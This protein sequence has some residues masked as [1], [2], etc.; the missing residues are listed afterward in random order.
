MSTV[1]ANTALMTS[2]AQL[3]VH[4]PPVIYLLP[5]IPP[6][7][8]TPLEFSRSQVQFP[9]SCAAGLLQ[10]GGSS[11]LWQG[12][13]KRGCSGPAELA[14]PLSCSGVGAAGQLMCIAKGCC[15]ERSRA[16]RS[17]LCSAMS[18]MLMT[19][20]FVMWC[21]PKVCAFIHFSFLR[22]A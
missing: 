7:I 4:I 19:A 1:H 13:S 11:W 20:M 3:A 15:E 21:V 18:A 5:W 12:R 8:D 17:V 14:L 6:M 10:G 22:P 16:D 2:A 9:S